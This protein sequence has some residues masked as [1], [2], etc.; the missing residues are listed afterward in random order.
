MDN[1][2]KIPLT[3]EQASYTFTQALG[4]KGTAAEAQ[5]K[6]VE[7]KLLTEATI[8]G[9][10]DKQKLTNADTYMMIRD[11]KIGLTGKP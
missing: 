7:G 11:V 3:L 1:A 10:A 5:A 8:N 9:I 4:I 2:D 6:L